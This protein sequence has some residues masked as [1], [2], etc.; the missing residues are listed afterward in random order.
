[1]LSDWPRVV[2][3]DYCEKIGSGATPKGG[4]SVYLEKGDVCL[5]RSQNIYNEGFKPDGLVYLDQQS[6]AKLKNVTVEEGDVLIN[7]TGDSVARVCSADPKYL[8]ARVNQHVA[9]IRPLKTA[10]DPRFIRYYLAMPQVQYFLLSLASTGG[11]RNALT[12]GMLESL[13]VPKPELHIQTRIADILSGLDEK[14]AINQQINATLE[15]MAQAL[16][17]SW[18]VDFEPVKAKIAAKAA[19]ADAEGM[20]LAAMEALS[21][22]NAEALAKM[23]QTEPDRYA[24]LKTTAEL[25]P[26]ALVDSELG[27][28]PVGWSLKKLSSICDILN[29]H[30]FKSKDYVDD[31]IFVFRTKNFTNGFAE[32]LTDDVFLPRSFLESHKQFICEPFDFHLVMVG[33]SLGKTAII[34]PHHLP[35]LRNQNMWCFRP[36]KNFPSLRYVHFISNDVINK[37]LSWASGSARSFFRKGDFQNQIVLIPEHPIL[38]KFEKLDLPL[39]QAISN[40]HK[41]QQNLADLRDTLL[42]KLLSGEVSV[43][44][45]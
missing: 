37:L 41:E 17:K 12:K 38:T 14:I 2:L 18:F 20:T 29:G 25:F 10:F 27:E 7:I 21:G 32:R 5:I 28:I 40:N 26:D 36:K 39:L 6:A 24:E 1:M 42:P 22:Q 23:A 44:D 34:L 4:S 30:A 16:F 35:A 3:G 45:V 9:I 13:E 33:A 8:P 11:T 31:G 15:A 43:A 19:G